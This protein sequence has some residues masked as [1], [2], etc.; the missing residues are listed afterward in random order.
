M[1]LGTM[2]IADAMIVPTLIIVESSSPSCRLS[3]GISA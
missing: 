3:S 1:A 2:K